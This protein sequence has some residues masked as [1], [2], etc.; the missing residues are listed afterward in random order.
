MMA[1]FHDLVA[2]DAPRAT[3]CPGKVHHTA[4]TKSDLSGHA[5]PGVPCVRMRLLTLGFATPTQLCTCLAGLRSC[6]EVLCVPEDGTG[7]ACRHDADVL[8]VAVTGL[9][10]GVDARGWQV[11][12]LISEAGL[13]AVDADAELLVQQ[14][15]E[16]AFWWRA[17][18][19]PAAH[20][21]YFPWHGDGCA[22]HEF[23]DAQEFPGLVLGQLREIGNPQ[24]SRCVVL[25][26]GQSVHDVE[27]QTGPRIRTDG[28]G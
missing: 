2:E 3:A 27:D 19:G 14:R 11:D 20:H 1:S 28:F 21:K 16:Q 10:T 13:L 12:L 24:L 5:E 25:D 18:A 22:A 23:G 15:G 9:A 8:V 17:G 7:T 6:R 26:D 4:S